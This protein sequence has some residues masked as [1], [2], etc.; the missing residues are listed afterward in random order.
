M[1]NLLSISVNPI[2]QDGRLIDAGMTKR[3][4]FS[5]AAMQACICDCGAG[6]IWVVED[7]AEDAVKIADCLLAA[8]SK[9]VSK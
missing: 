2:Y 8:L 6:Q 3:E 9:E 5:L 1:S 4:L 7:I